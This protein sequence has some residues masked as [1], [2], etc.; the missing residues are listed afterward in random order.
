MKKRTI[1]ALSAGIAAILCAG[2]VSG[3][4]PTFDGGNGSGVTEITFMV[5]SGCMNTDT[6]LKPA[7]QRF[8]E[9]K[10]DESYEE[11]K[12]GVSA[13]IMNDKELSY[14]SAML[15]YDVL[16]GENKTNIYDMQAKGWLCDISDIV[17]KFDDKIDPSIKERMK[18]SDG[19]YY[20]M[21]FHSFYC[22]LSYNV[23]L[24]DKYNFY[25]AAPEEDDVNEI[26]SIFASDK[27]GKITENGG[28]V[29]LI[30]SKEAKKSCG[31]NG[32]YGDY[33]DGLPSSVEE[34]LVFCDYIK[35]QGINPFAISG[36]GGN[37]NYGFMIVNAIWSGLAG[38]EMNNVY[39]NWTGN[40]VEVV[41]LD[42]N[43]KT[44]LTD[45][46][47]FYVGSGVKKPVTEKIVLNDENGYRMYDM[48][49][50]YYGLGVLQV[51]YKNGWFCEADWNG[52][53]NLDTQKD[54]VYGDMND[55][56]EN[57]SAMLVD[58]SYWYGE[59]INA[60]NIS[61]YAKVNPTDPVPH[62]SIMPMPTTYAGQVAENEGKKPVLLDTAGSLLFVSRDVAKNS[63]KLRAVKEFIEYFYTNELANFTEATG[64]QI[65]MDYDY[66][67]SKQDEFYGMMKDI[68]DDGIIIRPSSANAKYKSAA[69]SFSISWGGYINNFNMNGLDCH[70]GPLYAMINNKDMRDI[71]E[72][73]RRK[74][75]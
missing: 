44:V 30:G 41:K 42:S 7:M 1:K 13:A 22:G 64:L 73:T 23:G 60:K 50:R 58:S 52:K 49:A 27:N 63:G 10:K 57:R 18:G 33:D 40:E 69:S 35:S 34:F 32:V 29:R 55:K 14:N 16:I 5:G 61:D 26:E 9:L 51:A 15:Q 43:G 38:E 56:K 36:D 21:P 48:V 11:G 45:E 17:E 65:P 74:T 4:N 62:V 75:W 24:L 68:T 72:V 46:D 71:F 25:F 37:F 2:L 47:L 28:S 66:D 39:C 12:V 67:S 19:K 59:S 8:S 31:P 70:D 6:W 53:S 20:S 3:C 54:F